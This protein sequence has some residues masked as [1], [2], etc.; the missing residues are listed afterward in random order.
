[1]KKRLLQAIIIFMFTMFLPLFTAG[2]V[3][4][5][6]TNVEAPQPVAQGKCGTSVFWTLFRFNGEGVLL[7]TGQGDMSNYSYN[8]APWYF[9]R[10]NMTKVVITE[11]VT[12][13][14]SNAFYYYQG[15][16]SVTLGPDVKA[17]ESNAFSGCVKIQKI[18]VGNQVTRLGINALSTGHDVYFAGTR[19]EWEAM[20]GDQALSYGVKAQFAYDDAYDLSKNGEIIVTGQYVYNTYPQVPTVTVKNNGVTLQKER[21]YSI[22]VANSINAGKA[23]VKIYGQGQY[24]GVL[25]AQFLIEPVQLSE[26]DVNGFYDMTYT[27][28]TLFPSYS[29]S[30]TFE[31]LKKVYLEPG[32]DY[33]VVYKDNINAGTA[34]A[35]INGAGN[36]KGTI[37]KT[38]KIQPRSLYLAE[39]SN[40]VE[41]TYKGDAVTQK[42]TVKMYIGSTANTL[43]KDRDYKLTYKN[44]KTPGTATV[45][46]EGMGNY[47]DSVTRTFSI[48]KGAAT[49]KFEKST[50]TKNKIGATFTNKVTTASK[51]KKTYKSSNSSV[52]KVNSKGEVTTKG[53]GKATITVTVAATETFKEATAKYTVV[54]NKVIG[55]SDLRYAFS[56]SFYGFSYPSNYVIPYSRYRTVFGSDADSVYRQYGGR[57]WGGNCFGMSS[58]ASLMN[59]TDSGVK[60]KHFKSSASKV[61]DLGLSNHN[62]RMDLTLKQYIEVMQVSQY[63]DSRVQEWRSHYNDLEGCVKAVKAVASN[64]QPV[65][66][67]IYAPTGGHAVVGYE[68]EKVNDE[69]SRIRIYDPN[70]PDEKRFITLYTKNGKFTGWYYKMNDRENWGSNYSGCYMSYIT[71]PTYSKL[72]TGYNKAANSLVTN[73]DNFKLKDKNGN[74]VA[75]MVEGVFTSRTDQI[76]EMMPMDADL[77]GHAI[78]L[79]TGNYSFENCQ[80]DLGTL[81]LRTKDTI[82]TVDAENTAL[83]ATINTDSA[84]GT[85]RLE[86]SLQENYKVRFDSLMLQ[87]EGIDE[88]VFDGVGNGG[89][90]LVGIKDG[91]YVYENCDR[92]EISVNGD[93]VEDVVPGGALDPF[94]D[95]PDAD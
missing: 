83:T 39:I 18:T 51:G 52:A 25:E 42:P 55:W 19:Q 57:T 33:N 7:I 5:D 46:I 62:D 59:N 9:Y 61:H 84:V 68:F 17:I 67:S 12:S 1:M 91:Q 79:P 29:I 31:S 69:K 35:T 94:D 20:K 63:A 72:W 58:T 44:N 38:Y 78:L 28:N 54:V 41:K 45:I 88:V 76:L 14:G 95:E 16:S 34:K 15:L 82:L 64:S 70:F 2:T 49:V 30:H 66:V 71:F 8:T 43:K 10:H 73:S 53:Y 56:N 36:Y 87:R 3:S 37:I 24:K 75:E 26:S 60:V 50:I 86:P 90:M 13:V 21:D 22:A 81:D 74:V 77:Q 65:M 6:T 4:A 89:E 85:V 80:E 48:T 23:T 47:K 93:V 11:G 92:L 32:R 40:I 27:G